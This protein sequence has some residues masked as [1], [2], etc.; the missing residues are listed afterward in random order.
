MFESFFVGYK[1]LNDVSRIEKKHSFRKI[2]QNQPKLKIKKS[3]SLNR[4]ACGDLK[5]T[6]SIE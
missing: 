3:C 5:C 4:R 1:K 6:P 2:Y